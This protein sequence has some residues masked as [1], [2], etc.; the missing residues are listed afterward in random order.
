V[1]CVLLFHEE[2]IQQEFNQYVK[3]WQFISLWQTPI[4]KYTPQVGIE[5][6]SQ[7]LVI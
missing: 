3:E 1:H 5:P 4:E 7:I 6:I 2:K